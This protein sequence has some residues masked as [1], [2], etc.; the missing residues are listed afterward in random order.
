MPHICTVI[1]LYVATLARGH[2]SYKATISENKLC[3]IVSNLPLT[4][5]HPSNKAR[6][7]IPQGWPYKRATTVFNPVMG[8]ADFRGRWSVPLKY[9]GLS[10]TESLGGSLAEGSN[11]QRVSTPPPPPH[12]HTPNPGCMPSFFTQY[13]LLRT[14]L[15]SPRFY[16]CVIKK[17]CCCWVNLFTV[18]F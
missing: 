9:Q 16:K 13:T 11:L 15:K 8:M 4:R 3:I 12:T 1:P 5:G 18:T 10:V 6:F 2:P 14:F 7:C 17:L